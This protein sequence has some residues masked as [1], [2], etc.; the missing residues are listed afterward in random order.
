MARKR[1][2]GARG[3]LLRG[4]TL[5]TIVA[6]LGLSGGVVWLL[7]PQTLLPEAAAATVS[8]QVVTVTAS[9]TEI[10]FVP[11]VDTRRTALIFYPGA[12]VPVSGYAPA[13]RAIA[14][15]GFRVYLV[16]MPGNFAL[17]AAD[18][19]ADVQA[20]HPEIENW[21]V[22]GHSLGGV[23]AAQFAARNLSRVRGLAL[24]AS[25]PND[26]LSQ[27]GLQVLSI[28]GSLD[29]AR[30]TFTSDTTRALLP[31]GTRYIEIPGG[32]HEQFGYYTGQANDPQATL[33]RA[34][35]QAAIVE[36]TVALLEAV[37]RR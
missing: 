11:S 18:R 10:S 32:N 33:S 7:T 5:I 26:D 36:A 15:Q 14:E 28:W 29:S 17:L 6:L 35:Q 24:W 1:M 27:S 22:A 2:I 23:A 19:A 9:D 21:V 34:D 30:E 37:D 12:K 16:P 31:P 8:D 25:Y 20:A 13:A 4:A 3:W